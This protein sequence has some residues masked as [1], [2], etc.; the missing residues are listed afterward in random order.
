MLD[1]HHDIIIKK[2]KK[3][4]F[5]TSEMANSLKIFIYFVWFDISLF[6]L[7]YFTGHRAHTV[8]VGVHMP[9]SRRHSHRR[10]KHHHKDGDKSTE[11]DRPSKFIYK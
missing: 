8:F 1:H 11:Y 6:T 3:N 9:G 5:E 7:L 4:K 10:H 2:K